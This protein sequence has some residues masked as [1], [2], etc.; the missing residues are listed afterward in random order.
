M[1]SNAQGWF[2]AAM[3]NC[4]MQHL[5]LASPW[6]TWYGCKQTLQTHIA[7]LHTQTAPQ[8]L[9]AKGHQDSKTSRTFPLW[10]QMIQIILLDAT[11]NGMLPMANYSTWS[12][13]FDTFTPN[14]KIHSNASLHLHVECPMTQ[15]AHLTFSETGHH[16]IPNYQTAISL[17]S[18]R[19]DWLPLLSMATCNFTLFN[20]SLRSICVNGC[21]VFQEKSVE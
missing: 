19:W 9:P 15:V 3:W 12:K 17:F 21:I 11:K 8:K 14:I 7:F 1:V 16:R 13:Y 5:S 20:S 18:H 2:L 6:Q 10:K 4:A